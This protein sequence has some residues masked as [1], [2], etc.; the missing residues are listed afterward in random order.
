MTQGLI[1]FPVFA[2]VL[3]TFGIGV[4]MLKLRFKAVREDGLNPGYFQLNR[5]AKLPDYLA[6]V[7]NHYDNLFELPILFYVACTILY[8]GNKADAV[9]V[10][11]AWLFV[12][13]RY[14]HA[15][16]HTT[17]NDLKH[18]RLAFLCG[19]LVLASLWVKLA[20][21]TIHS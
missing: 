12:G 10:G 18:R 3:L 11:L 2:M 7:T 16:I 6:K 21:Q 17:Y 4:W 20:I 19:S 8:A 9:S 13:I 1:L 14:T 5:G 15:Y